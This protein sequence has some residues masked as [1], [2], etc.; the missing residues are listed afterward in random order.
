ML[1]SALYLKLISALLFLLGL[2]FLFGASFLINQ[3]DN[4]LRR[5]LG[6]RYRST[7]IPYTRNYQDLFKP[8]TPA[9]IDRNRVHSWEVFL[10]SFGGALIL[11][12]LLFYLM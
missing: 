1:Q 8:S 3:Y 7:F 11:V 4:W 6:I 12:G 5:K 9:Q 10:R 2:F